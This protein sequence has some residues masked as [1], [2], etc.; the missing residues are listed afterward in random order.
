MRRASWGWLCVALLLAIPGRS[1]ARVLPLTEVF[2]EHNQWCWAAVSRTVLLHYNKNVTQCA[3]AEYVRSVATWH[4][5]GTI[6]CCTNPNAGCNY[7]NYLLPVTAGSIP[8]IFKQFGGSA[9]KG[10]SAKLTA[11]ELAFEIKQ[12]RPFIIRWG[13]PSGSGHFIVIHGITGSDK[14]HYMDPWFGEG[15]KIASYSWIVKASNH[16]WTH[17]L[18]T[19]D[20]LCSSVDACCDGCKAKNE[21]GT[22]GGT[23]PCADKAGIC[24]WG[25]CQGSGKLKCVPQSQCHAAGTCDPNTGKCSTP[26]LTDGTSCDDGNA[27]SAADRCSG[28]LCQGGSWTRCAPTGPCQHRSRCDPQ[29]GSCSSW[30]RADGTPCP[31]GRCLGGLCVVTV[32]DSAPAGSPDLQAPVSD[33]GTPAADRGSRDSAAPAEEPPGCGC[34]LAEPSRGVSFLLLVVLLWGRKLRLCRS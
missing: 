9:C 12:S 23:D 27:C 17:T 15:K 14:V 5:F 32:L 34:G 22:C 3:I 20:C 30:D 8:D 18:T 16:S 4:N 21:G 28:G 19:G 26:P 24:R 10:T 33:G 25:V 11:K 6:N 31:G 13:R 2:Q 29:T 1:R 7:W